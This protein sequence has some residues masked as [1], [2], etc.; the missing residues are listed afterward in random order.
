MGTVIHIKAWR[1]AQILQE[2]AAEAFSC[3]RGCGS[4]LF[5]IHGTGRVRCARC[6]APINVSGEPMVESG[7]WIRTL[8]SLF[9][10]EQ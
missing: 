9:K 6:S 7:G 4:R 3:C 5:R 1:D 10:R 2:S 8:R